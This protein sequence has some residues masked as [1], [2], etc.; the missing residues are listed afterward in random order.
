MLVNS[1]L[2]FKKK[3]RRRRKRGKEKKKEEEEIGVVAS[4]E[5]FD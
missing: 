3:E 1:P 4:V 5:T 2:S